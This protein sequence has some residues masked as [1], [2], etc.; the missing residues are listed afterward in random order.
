[1]TIQKF[2]AKHKTK[3]HSKPYAMDAFSSNRM[4]K[5]Q[6]DGLLEQGKTNKMNLSFFQSYQLIV[7]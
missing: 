1:M 3:T 6:P 4:E 5:K 2:V 7:K